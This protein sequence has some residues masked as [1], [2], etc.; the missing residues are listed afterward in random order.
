MQNM[1]DFGVFSPEWDVSIT[2]FPSRVRDLHRRGGSG[3]VIR[4]RGGDR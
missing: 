1:R 2:V 3:K 4:V